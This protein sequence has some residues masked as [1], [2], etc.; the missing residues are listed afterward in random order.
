MYIFC[1]ILYNDELM[2][3]SEIQNFVYMNN[4]NL[5]IALRIIIPMIKITQIHNAYNFTKIAHFLLQ[6]KETSLV[7]TLGI[8]PRAKS[9]KTRD[10]TRTCNKKRRKIPYVK[11]EEKKL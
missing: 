2:L 7:F 9:H 4:N 8:T 3:I 6:G 5:K 11:L 10:K 1:C